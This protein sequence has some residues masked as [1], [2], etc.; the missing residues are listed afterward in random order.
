MSLAVRRNSFPRIDN[1]PKIENP[2]HAR[3]FSCPQIDMSRFAHLRPPRAPTCCERISL[4]FQRIKEWFDNSC[5][6][7]MYYRYDPYRPFGMY[8]YNFLS[9][10]YNISALNGIFNIYKLSTIFRKDWRECS[11]LEKF[12]HFGKILFILSIPFALYGLGVAIRDF[13]NAEDRINCVL[14]MGENLS[15]LGSSA[16]T[17]TV[18]LYTVGAGTITALIWAFAFYAAGA[19]LGASTTVLNWIDLRKRLQFRNE[20]EKLD[21]EASWKVAKGKSPQHLSEVLN[22]P[23]NIAN[24]FIKSIEW[25]LDKDVAIREANNRLKNRINQQAFFG[26]IA[27]ISSAVSF[28]GTLILLFTP[29]FPVAYGLLALSAGLS[30]VRF[31]YNHKSLK[32]FS[33]KTQ[34]GFRLPSVS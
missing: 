21:A 34:I 20:I 9:N 11:W 3:R 13:V 22:V 24:T 33:A 29:I 23:V 1:N 30:M 28:I 25:R 7:K 8:A 19:V 6:G 5:I 15:W 26:K 31:Y 16:G 2:S 4:C 10:T 18:G 12:Q 32:D 27:V 17:L 14:R